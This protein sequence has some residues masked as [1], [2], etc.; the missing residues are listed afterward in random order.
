MV[1]KQSQGPHFKPSYSEGDSALCNF[2]IE[3]SNIVGLILSTSRGD[4]TRNLLYC[5]S[6]HFDSGSPWIAIW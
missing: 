6:V 4:L 3:S 2:N 1:N 5:D